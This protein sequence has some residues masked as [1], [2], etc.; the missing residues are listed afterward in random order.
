MIVDRA[1]RLG[2]G[3]PCRAAEGGYVYHVLNRANARMAIFEQEPEQCVSA[4]EQVHSTYSLKSSH[5]FIIA[6]ARIH[7]QRKLMGRP[8]FRCQTCFAS[9]VSD[10]HRSAKRVDWSRSAR[11]LGVGLV[12][13]ETCF[14]A[15]LGPNAPNSFHHGTRHQQSHQGDQQPQAPVPT[16]PAPSMPN[17]LRRPRTRRSMDCTPGWPRSEHAMDGLHGWAWLGPSFAGIGW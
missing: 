1:S 4:E 10:P 16:T 9:H 17:L 14:Y 11:C 6:L 7:K 2:I 3:R 5:R 8:S 15:R 13:L 12:L